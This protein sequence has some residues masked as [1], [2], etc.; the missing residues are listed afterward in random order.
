MVSE[1]KNIK[2]LTADTSDESTDQLE[3]LSVDLMPTDDELE[4]DADTFA[5][6]LETDRADLAGLEILQ[7]D[8]RSKDER[9][10]NLQFD[11]EQLRSRWSGLEKEISAR[12][13]V[14]DQLQSELRAAHRSAHAKDK[15]LERNSKRLDELRGKLDASVQRTVDAED[16]VAELELLHAELTES[17]ENDAATIHE[18]QQELSVA[19]KLAENGEL[20]GARLAEKSAELSELKKLAESQQAELE[21]QAAD[22]QAT[23]ESLHSTEVQ[24]EELAAEVAEKN[25]QVADLQLKIDALTTDL[26]KGSAELD[27]SAHQLEANSKRIAEL[28][29]ELGTVS[30]RSAELESQLE[31]LTADRETQSAELQESLDSLR[32]KTELAA[33]LEAE[34]G[35]KSTEISKLQEQAEARQ[36]EWDKQSVE[37][38]QALDAL[39]ERTERA[40]ELESELADKSARIT[41]LDAAARDHQAEWE[42]QAAELK[43]TAEALR[44]S[45]ALND[46][47]SDK[48]SSTETL[49]EQ[50]LGEAASLAKTLKATQDSERALQSE[51]AELRSQIDKHVNVDKRAAEKTIAELRGNLADRSQRIT[52]L[53]S[54]VVRSES[55]ADDIRDQ[56][57][58]AQQERTLFDSLQQDAASQLEDAV[59]KIADLESQLAFEKDRSETLQAQGESRDERIREEVDTYRSELAE[60][61]RQ[62]A[63]LSAASEQLQSEL[64]KTDA[65][66]QALEQQLESNMADHESSVAALQLRLSALETSASEH[67]E[68]L[69]SKDK[70]IAALLSELANKTKTLESIDEIEDVIQDIGVRMSEKIDDPIVTDRDRTTRLL[71]GSIDGQELRFPLFKDRLTI[72]R[73]AQ[74]DIQLRAQHISRRHAVIVVDTD[75]TKI[76][77]WGSKNGVYVN[78]ARVTEQKLTSGDA[79]LIGN[80]EFVYEELARRSAD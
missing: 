43:D 22:L 57:S 39:Q 49:L 41:Q 16:R 34:L 72:G 58:H 15:A 62:L 75:G 80:A 26:E 46:E 36:T 76:V 65:L 19:Q 37:L 33:K 44:N 28:E 25:A 52:K 5:L 24:A 29:S 56:L 59:D 4:M 8:L 12:E 61:N 64:T 13:E 77:D 21:Q 71:V 9:I 79:L 53:E 11:I 74:N 10:S 27:E 35:E 67:E 7:S 42:R 14:T 32:V 2:S 54:Q 40:V 69:Q 51:M 70:A 31:S 23:H 60:A 20:Y 18:L 38:Q 1:N 78:N 63:D 66:K 6:Q 50:G 3:V 68:K 30:N 55:Y 17:A 73:T 47:L 45:K 48:L